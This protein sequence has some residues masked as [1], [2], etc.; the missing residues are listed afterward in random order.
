MAYERELQAALAA[1]EAAGRAVLE[2]YDTFVPVPNAPADITTEADHQ[3]QEIILRH[4]HQAFPADA[5]S[6]E[7][8]TGVPVGAPAAGSRLWI[9][10]PID[11]TRGFARKN[12][13]F[14]LMVAFVHDGQVAVGVVM[15]PAKGQLTYA[16]LGGGCWRRDGGAAEP[17]RCHVTQTKEL[18]AA[19]LTQSRSRSGAPSAMVIALRPARV[20]ETYSAGIKMA[21]V[22]R[23][24]ADLYVNDYDA[25]HDWD[26]AAGHLLV[27]EAGG[28]VTSS[29]GNALQYG[30]PGAW[31]REGMLATNGLLHA[32]VLQKI[33]K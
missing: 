24:E 2:R 7:E 18:S 32:A 20:L 28:Q 21:Q 16:S 29:K 22:A 8:T 25:F 33:A 31:Q 12:G 23:G 30:L 6:A 26:I 14:S 4:L 19:T 15:E 27:T 10:D 13:E 5:L 9:V 1:A 3:A 17:V 11:G